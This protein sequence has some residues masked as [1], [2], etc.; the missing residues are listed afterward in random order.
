[1]SKLL[2][3]LKPQIIF[4][5]L[6]PLFMFLEVFT[7]LY[8][9]K[10]MAQIMDFGV[11]NND[12]NFIKIVGLKTLIFAILGLIGG[13][14]CAISASVASQ[15]FGASVRYDLFKKVQK[16]S[17]VNLDKFNTSS[18]ITRLTNDINQ[19]QEV[20][21]TSLR[22]LVRAPLIFF[23]G[24]IMAFSINKTLTIVLIVTIIILTF[25]VFYI[26]RLGLPL[27]KVVQEKIDNVNVVMRENLVGIKVV[28]A[29]VR[30]DFEKEKFKKRNKDL[31][32]FTI[33]AFKVMSAILPIMMVIMNMSIIFIL[34]F[35][36]HQ[37]NAGNMQTGD[38]MAFITYS[39][40]ILTA[41]ILV[42]MAIMLVSR[43]KA[44]IQRIN[45]VLDEEVSI[46]NDENALENCITKGKIEFKNVSFKYPV[47]N[48]EY[49]LKD[50][51][52]TIEPGETIGILG[53]TGSGKSTLVNL[54]LR[55]YDVSEGEILIDGINIKKISL[56]YLRNSI[57]IVLQKAVLF[58]GT[59]E[60][61]IK[62][63]KKDATDE[64]VLNAAKASQAFEFIEKIPEKFKSPV[65]QMG[66]NFSGG[67]K[68]RLSI[69]RTLIKKPKILI[70]DDS[71]SAV[72]TETEFKIQKA[73]KE[74]IPDSTKIVIAQK[75][76]TVK[77]MD[78]IIIIQD[79][80]IK[81]IGNHKQLLESSF[82]Y[83]EIYNSQVKEKGV[84]IN[85]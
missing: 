71:T 76:S 20:V 75:I 19:V 78:K 12:I 48:S 68:Q 73:I 15:N 28:R 34:Y 30:E 33:K 44:S 4:V 5:I 14:G 47:E 32:N 2:K 50:I 22:L 16:F 69:A 37:I 82:I 39:T 9:P 17:F 23:G 79:S 53:G 66:S 10:L 84:I 58:S 38:L 56:E 26:L 40:Q 36:G 35:G 67:Q 46:I 60:E 54:I 80:Q 61:N 49:I 65:A 41:L 6:A 1:M 74:S 57:G 72:D 7:E 3:Y 83:Q 52:L 63:G 85:E 81:D 64:Q 45:E 25:A 29:F 62:W 21:M 11:V 42:G 70:L 43:G 31:K 77:N 18:L 51:N 27:F 55:L 13:I 8:I 59:I 24:I